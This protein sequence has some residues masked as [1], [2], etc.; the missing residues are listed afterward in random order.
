M[1][2]PCELVRTDNDELLRRKRRIV[3]GG[4]VGDITIS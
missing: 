1:T 3:V 2:S 4:H